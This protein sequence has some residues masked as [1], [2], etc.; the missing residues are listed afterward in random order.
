MQQEAG[1][2]GPEPRQPTRRLCMWYLHHHGRRQEDPW[3]T[4]TLWIAPCATRLLSAGTQA[5]PPMCT[6]I[7]GGPNS[8]HS[9]MGRAQILRQATAHAPTPPQAHMGLP[10]PQPAACQQAVK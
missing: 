1:Q 5:T 8:A 7:R 10:D 2:L 6:S 3:G 9:G 4:G